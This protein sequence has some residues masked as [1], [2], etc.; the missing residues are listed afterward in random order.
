MRPLLQSP[1]YNHGNGVVSPDG[2]WLAYQSNESNAFQVYVRPFPDVNS[3]RWQISLAGGVKPIWAPDGRE[4]FY[5]AGT[6]LMSA[7]I[8]TTPVFSA[9]NPVKVLDG[10]VDTGPTYGRHYDVSRDGRRFVVIKNPA[11]A[12]PGG[13]TQ[14]QIVLALNWTDDVKSKLQK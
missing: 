4:L 1:Q 10:I 2:R 11:P 6:A 12:G 14:P 13:A 3:G 7:S 8:Q 5:M 9:G